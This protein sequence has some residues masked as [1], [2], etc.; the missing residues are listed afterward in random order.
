MSSTQTRKSRKTQIFNTKTQQ[1]P[2]KKLNYIPDRGHGVVTQHSL[3]QNGVWI[4]AI[5]LFMLCHNVTWSF[6][7]LSILHVIQDGKRYCTHAKRASKIERI[8]SQRFTDDMVLLS[9]TKGGLQQHLDLVRPGP[10]QSMSVIKKEWC[11]KKIQ[12]HKYIYNIPDGID[13]FIYQMEYIYIY[14]FLHYI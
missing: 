1:L 12:D 3:H 8:W 14:I 7:C 2:N 10:W 5:G 9:S 6:R 11:L 13:I 4:P